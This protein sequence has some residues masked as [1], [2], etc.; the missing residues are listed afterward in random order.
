MLPDLEELP[1]VFRAG[2]IEDGHHIDHGVGVPDARPIPP[3]QHCHVQRNLF[4]L[5]HQ[6]SIVAALVAMK[7][8]LD[9]EI[10]LRVEIETPST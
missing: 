8:G 5:N 1:L 10:R 4:H 7:L 9:R 6:H 3:L 2:D